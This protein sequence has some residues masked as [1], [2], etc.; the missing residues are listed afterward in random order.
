MYWALALLMAGLLMMTAGCGMPG[1]SGQD[2]EGTAYEVTDAAG[3]VLT[4][5]GKP[6]RIVSMTVSTD[7]ILTA[8]VPH[9]RIA[10]V[11]SLA[12]DPGVSNIAGQVQDIQ[13]RV[14]GSDAE[15]LM[16]LRPDLVLVSDFMDQGMVQ[17]LKDLGLPVYMYKTPKSTAE[18]EE[19]IRSL[20]QVTGEQEKAE[21]LAGSM[22]AQLDALGRVTGA[23]PEEQRKTVLYYTGSGIYALGQSSFQDICR[24]AGVK[25]V[26]DSLHLTQAAP[27][28]EETAVQLNPDVILV[29][30]WN[31][32]G[33]HDAH[34]KIQEILND[35]AYQSTSA[36]RNKQVFLIPGAHIL[37]LSQ[38]IVKAPE[39]IVSS[40]Y[41]SQFQTYEKE[42][43]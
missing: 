1:P 9:G 27:L 37:A 7:E 43:K 18:I 42:K 41:P 28:S 3:N 33:K 11:S 13:N 31:Y 6:Q 29:E 25:D 39:D 10:A 35:P 23:I 2:H 34:A 17:S 24:Y 40:V 4:L 12:D 20:G 16:A 5:K 14:S 22:Q 38:Y 36:V 21:E 32:D 19:V 15:K 30:N 26:T 8:L